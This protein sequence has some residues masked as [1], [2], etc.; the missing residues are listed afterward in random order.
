M[1]TDVADTA[2]VMPFFPFSTD[3]VSI[4]MWKHAAAQ[5]RYGDAAAYYSSL[6]G[7]WDFFWFV[8]VVL[9]ARKALSSE[10]F[11]TTVVVADPKVWAWLH[12]RLRLN[13]RGLLLVYRGFFFYG[14]GRM[15]SWF[16]YAR[17]EA[18]TPFQPTWGGPDYLSQGNDLSDSS[19]LTA[20]WHTTA[21]GVAFFSCMWILWRLFIGRL[22]ARAEDAPAV[23]RGIWHRRRLRLT[24]DAPRD[25]D[26]VSIPCRRWTTASAGSRT[27]TGPMRSAG[28]GPAMPRPRPT[29]SPNRGSPSCGRPPSRSSR[30]TT[31]SPC[32]RSAATRSA[33]SGPIASTAVACG[34]GPRGTAT[35]PT[36]PS[37]RCCSTSTPSGP[38]TESPGSSPVRTSVS[39]IDGGP[40]S[41]CRPGVQTPPSTR[42]FDLV[43]K[44]FVPADEGGF[45]RPLAKGWMSWIDA[46]TVYVAT[47]FGAGTMTRSGYP[48]TVRRWERGTPLADA[49]VV[50]EATVDD[51]GV[52]GGVDTLEGARHH[53]FDVRHDFYSGEIHLLRDGHLVQ[54][55][56]P[57][58]A[59]ATVRERWVFVELRTDWT[60]GGRTHPAGSLVAA[61][62]EASS[63]ATAV[64]EPLFEPTSTTSLVGWSFTRNH[65]VLNL[66]DDVR[67]RI[68]VGTPDG[69]PG[70]APRS[71]VPRTCGPSPPA[72]SRPTTDDLWLTVNDFVTPPLVA[73]DRHRRP[74]RGP[75]Q[76]DAGTLRRRRPRHRAALRRERRRH[77]GPVLPG[78]A[79]G[80]GR[81]TGPDP[82]RRL[83]RVRGRQRG[84]L[85][86]CAR[87]L[88]AGGGR[89]LRAGQHPGRRRVRPGVAPGRAQASTAT[90]STRT[91]RPWPATSSPPASPRPTQLGCTGGSN[92]GLLV[93][94][95][96]VRSPE[97][98]GAIV[99]QVPLLDMKRYPHLLAGASWM[100]EYGDPD[101]DDWAFIQTFSPYHLVDARPSYPPILLTTS[102]QDDRVHPGHARKMAARLIELGKDVT[103]WENVEGGHG[104]AADAP[105][106]ATMQALIYTFL[107]RRLMG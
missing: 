73:A 99:C 19:F 87:T 98:W 45:V 4:S 46:D 3:N 50:F 24:R 96:Y 70:R 40:S 10:Y 11:R 64:P 28:C 25:D 44:R 7:V 68:E 36:L 105:Q 32:P 62:L 88:V 17:F 41:A 71:P 90:G 55:D 47:D 66:L 37:G 61:D 29:C 92:G 100:A 56:V 76:V 51:M 84:R 82:A 93:G 13:Q 42:E 77:P 22:W 48:R 91:S 9:F 34:D 102:T 5:G 43:D 95:M 53:V 27:S 12:N 49:E 6:G 63:P 59:T 60:V 101:T 33:T 30:P 107:R 89:H 79:T 83:R 75:G 78:A 67:S 15:V 57:G 23:Q 18:R 65:V 35:G 103:Y 72:R 74:G 14:L 81:D 2:G 1:L 52:W 97:L 38:P 16:L 39:P 69:R 26:T 94:N 104:G 8:V 106:Q 21:G 58:D 86:R 54:L 20:L 80:P 31:A 85:R